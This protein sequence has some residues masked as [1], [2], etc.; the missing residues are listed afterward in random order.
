LYDALDVEVELVERQLAEQALARPDVRQLMT[1]PGAG[2]ITALA[3]VAVI[4]DVTRFPGPRH[5][6]GY[7]GL[8]P[9]VRQPGETAA[10]HGTSRALGRHTSAGC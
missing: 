8:D 9:R 6:V 3:L 4:G 5:L 1:I 7:L 2:A 10:R